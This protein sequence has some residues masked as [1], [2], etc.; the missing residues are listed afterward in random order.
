MSIK[1][2]HVVWF[3]KSVLDP[4]LCHT[5]FGKSGV[6]QGPKSSYSGTVNS[7]LFT[8]KGFV[9][10]VGILT[11]LP[12]FL[13]SA[14]ATKNLSQHR[15]AGLSLRFELPVAIIFTPL[16]NLLIY[17]WIVSTRG[18]FTH[19][20]KGPSNILGCSRCYG[21]RPLLTALVRMYSCTCYLISVFGKYWSCAALQN[22][23]G[24]GYQSLLILLFGMYQFC[25]T[26]KSVFSGH[27]LLWAPELE[28]QNFLLT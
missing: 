6:L 3:Q 14:A 7:W 11:C 18:K 13:L 4:N 15:L 10:E 5:L 9:L 1:S 25:Y 12:I 16:T 21:V 26:L 2:L 27:A 23:E 8:L 24:F 17:G 19:N 28:S 20:I 22:S